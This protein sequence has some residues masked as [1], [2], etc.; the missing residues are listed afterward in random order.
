[1]RWSM[2][3]F[4]VAA[5]V[6]PGHGQQLEGFEESGSRDMRPAAQVGESALGVERDDLRRDGF[7]NFEL[8]VFAHP[9]KERL[10]LVFGDLTAGKRVVGLGDAAHFRFDGGQVVRGEGPLESEVVI[11]AVFDGRAD[12][13]LGG[14]KE[15]FDRL[16]HDV[17]GGVADDFQAVGAIGR[18]RNEFGAGFRQRGGEV[19]QGV[20][21]ARGHRV[22][23]P[24]AA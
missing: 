3:R 1:M 23:E 24:L 16:G 12:G 2:G 4:F 7:E 6:G 5:P 15:F 22:L 18:D 21:A 9:G 14:G 19:E 13:H 11:E 8:V 20:A 17:G 10:G